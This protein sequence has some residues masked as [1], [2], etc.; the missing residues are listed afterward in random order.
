MANEQALTREY[1]YLLNVDFANDVPEP[2]SLALMGAAMIGLSM[3]RR[4]KS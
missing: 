3:V 2:G 1:H 4:R